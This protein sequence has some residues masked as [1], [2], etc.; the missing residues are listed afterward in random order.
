M[1]P[2]EAPIAEMWAAL[3]QEFDVLLL[4]TSHPS[5]GAIRIAD[6]LFA[7][8]RSEAPFAG[9]P[10]ELVTKL[11][12]RHARLFVEQG[13]IFVADLD[14]K[15]GTCVNGTAVR[16]TPSRVRAGDELS[17]GNA[18]T[19]R[20]AIET[21]PSGPL[22]ARGAQHVTI[23]LQPERADL[24]LE[25]I[26]VAA[27]PFLVSKTDELFAR[28]KDRYP[29]QVN[30]I[31]RRHA[32]I[33]LK[34]G[35]PWIEDLGSTNGTFVNG[36]RLGD[37][38]HPLQDGDV[39]GFGGDHFVYRVLLQEAFE[40]EPTVTQTALGAAPVAAIAAVAAVDQPPEAAP[41]PAIDPDKTT[42]VGA[43]HSFLDIFCVDRALQ[44][45]DEINVEAA[46][47]APKAEPEAPA[48]TPRRRWQILAAELARTFSAGDHSMMRR[49]GW[50]ALGVCVIVAGIA[51]G[52]YLHGERE[53]QVKGLLAAGQYEAA[54]DAAASWLKQHPAGESIRSLASEALMKARV[55]GWLAALRGRQFD[56]ATTLVDGMRD[57]GNGNTDATTLIDQLQW[58]GD[59]E[60]FVVGRGGPDAPIRIY[61]DESRIRDLLHRWN[62][63][64]KGHQRVLDR[65]ASYVPE[66]AEPYALA[67]SHLRKL[68]SDDSVYLAAIDRLDATIATELARDDPQAL[69]AVL[70]DDAQRYPRLAGLD[71]VRAD[72]RQYTQLLDALRARHLAPLLAAMHEARFTTPPFEAQ[73]RQLAASRLPSADVV[74]RYDAVSAAW[75]N[76][77]S[78]RAL[79]G[80]AAMPAGP[81]SDMMTADL[82]RRKSVLAQFADLQK[83]RGSA[84]HDDKLLAFYAAID[85][86]DDVYYARAIQA[87]VDALRD[88]ALAHAN[89]EI[90]HAQT[91]WR[92]YRANGAIGGTQRLESGISDGFRNQAHLLSEANGD[93]QQGMRVFTQLKAPHPA[94]AD[95]LSSDIEAE[96]QL[97]RRSLDEL[98][99]VLDP[100]LLKSKLALIG[101]D[102]SETRQSP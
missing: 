55:P 53:R 86:A 41:L 85:P 4:P 42:F 83:S 67:M 88:R 98:R 30:Y 38:A 61:A 25:P 34:G 5:L 9:Y 1:N 92:Q 39:I 87:D 93:V 57:L 21:R 49:I 76:G 70:D 69:P 24:G 36:E 84:S 71:A 15:N 99:M 48:R 17:F 66:F 56:H 43:A 80:L 26:D 19:Y 90:A 23:A 59:L 3:D 72:L 35:E 28:Y 102:G 51:V 44:R 68:Q 97:Q 78:Q 18:L 12:R 7:I 58:V 89:D 47:I 54:A 16:Q 82:A 100:A 14:S 62:D 33:F 6:E 65:I 8:G 60:R 27:F 11:S 32:H 50:G 37:S 40:A 20:V 95:Q 52:I 10:Q 73:Y 31:S 64:A 94:G 29:H 45:E 63:D 75:R 101:G 2:G 91:L 22:S 77:D 13:A 79:D 74:A 96:T 46:A 81:W